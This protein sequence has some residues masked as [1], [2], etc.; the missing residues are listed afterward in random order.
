MY[1]RVSWSALDRFEKCSTRHRLHVARKRTQIP[2]EHVLVGNALHFGLSSAIDLGIPVQQAA[3][4]DFQRRLYEDKPK[5][6]REKL[7]EQHDRVVTGALAIQDVLREIT[8]NRSDAVGMRTE[9]R[10]LRAYKGWAID[11]YLD[12]MVGDGDQVWDLKTGRWHQDQVVF[13]DLLVRAVTG[14]S[15]VTVGIIEPFSRGLVPV[16]VSTEH[17]VDMQLRIKEFVR[18]VRDED[19]AFEGYSDKCS[20]CPCKPWCPKWASARDG[21]IGA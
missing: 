12:L 1:P 11:G 13:Y 6:D 4:W 21:V 3:L 9:V 2:V 7:A 16:P 20:W 14:E 19:W 10:M 5:W 8:V 17:R 18:R 15:P